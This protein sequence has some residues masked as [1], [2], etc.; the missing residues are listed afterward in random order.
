M[1]TSGFSVGNLQ[2]ADTVFS[3]HKTVLFNSYFSSNCQA[4]D[5]CVA[6]ETRVL[7]SSTASNFLDLLLILVHQDH[8]WSFRLLIWDLRS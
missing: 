2:I 5:S 8:S 3:D 6:V 4:N 7:S 1:L